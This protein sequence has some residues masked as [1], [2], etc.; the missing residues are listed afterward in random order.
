MFGE[1]W[2]NGTEVC[3]MLE[4]FWYNGMEIRTMLGGV[5]VQ[6]YGGAMLGEF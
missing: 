2:Y 1:F 5:L 3:T 6:W 4:E